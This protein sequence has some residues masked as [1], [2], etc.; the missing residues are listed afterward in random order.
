MLA[1]DV[2][3]HA[4]R[5]QVE[6]LAERGAETGGIQDGTRADHPLRGQAGELPG[7]ITEDIHRVGGVE[8]Q[9][10]GVVAQN[11]RDD[12]GEDGSVAFEQVQ[13]GLARFLGC[14]GG[15]DHHIRAGAIG[16]I[17][18]EDAGGMRKRHGIAQV[19]YLALGARLI[20]VDEDDLAHLPGKQQG[21]G[22][23]GAHLAAA[24]DG[25]LVGFEVKDGSVMGKYLL[26]VIIL[27]RDYK[28]KLPVRQKVNQPAREAGNQY[29]L[30]PSPALPIPKTD[31]EV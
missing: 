23:G 3:M 1:D 19:H 25:D 8:D 7:S 20:H 5:I 31:G 2:G 9:R 18:L 27:Q 10:L 22:E 30:H 6:A 29:I 24:D 26:P 16:I 12:P 17:A 28:E 11:L 21:I 15:D 13:A 4:A 14:P